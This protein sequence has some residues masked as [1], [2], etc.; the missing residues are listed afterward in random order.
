MLMGAKYDAKLYLFFH[1]D[2]L[3]LYMSQ[4]GSLRYTYILGFICK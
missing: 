1:M 3:E 2:I 4:I